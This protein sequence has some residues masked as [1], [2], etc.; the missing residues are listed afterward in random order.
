MNNGLKLAVMAVVLGMFLLGSVFTVSAQ[1]KKKIEDMTKEEKQAYLREIEKKR[2]KEKAAQMKAADANRSTG[3]DLETIIARWEKILDGEACIKKNERCADAM[4]TLGGLY[5]DQGRDN[6]GKATERHAEAMKQYNR[7]GRG[8]PPTPPVPD[9]S[10]SLSMYWRLSREFPNYPKLPE[11]YYQMSQ[12]YIVAGHL[13]TACTIL[14]NLVK[15]FPNSP[16]CSAARL[17]SGE[18]ACSDKIAQARQ[19]E[20]ARQTEQARKAEQAKQ[21][22]AERTAKAAAEEAAKT[23]QTARLAEAQAA[24]Q[25]ALDAAP[26]VPIGTGY[27]RVPWGA[28][29]ES[30]KK[31]YIDLTVTEKNIPDDLQAIVN[32]NDM[33]VLGHKNVGGGISEREFV[34]LWD[35]LT[36]VSVAY[37]SMTK[38]NTDLL[39]EKIVSIYGK[40]NSKIDPTKKNLAMVYMWEYNKKMK[41][42]LTIFDPTSAYIQLDDKNKRPPKQYSSFN[43]NMAD[44]EESLQMLMIAGLGP[45]AGI[46]ILVEY[47]DLPALERLQKEKTKKAEEDKKKRSDGLG[48]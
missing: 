6:F 30:V 5:Y 46:V 7:T 17:R 2:E 48:L 28:N 3:A 33:T 35:K 12:Y 47:E 44:L 23:E 14:D 10:K 11:V 20:Q 13:D 8:T 26:P 16:R 43:E 31:V 18:L 27:D 24:K 45:G 38:E 1:K 9:Y 41:I 36:K 40:P 34:F 32:N 42:T 37:T 22:Q 25:A 19:A 15:R 21:A 4:Y 39:F 29:V